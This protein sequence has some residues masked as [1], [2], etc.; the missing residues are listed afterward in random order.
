MLQKEDLMNALK[1]LERRRKKRAELAGKARQRRE[2]WIEAKI[3]L[4][5]KNITNDEPSALQDAHVFT[6]GNRLQ[7]CMD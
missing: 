4:L 3:D 6:K 7:A 5:G 2:G 1:D